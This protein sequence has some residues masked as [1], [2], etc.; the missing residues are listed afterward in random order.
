MDC[1][2]TA[3]ALVFA[4]FMVG[5]G[6][7]GSGDGGSGGNA[8]FSLAASAVTFDSRYDNSVAPGSQTVAA[9]AANGVVFLA[10]DYG[11]GPTSPISD[12]SLSTALLSSTATIRISPKSGRALGAGVFSETITVRGCTDSE[13]R[14]EVSG[15]PKRIAVTY[16]VSDS[17]PGITLGSTQLTFSG[18][19]GQPLPP[20]QDLIVTAPAGA[21]VPYT[22]S[23]TYNPASARDW[24]TVPPTGTATNTLPIKVEAT[25]FPGTHIATLTLTPTNATALPQSMV[26]H[27]QVGQPTL[28]FAPE[29]LDF[30]MTSASAPSELQQTV[31]V[32]G[33]GGSTLSWTASTSLPWLSINPTSGNTGDQVTVSLRTAQL[34]DL[35]PGDYGGFIN[36]SF[37]GASTGAAA[38][39]VRLSHRLPS[40]A[41]VTPYVAMTNST[42]QVI[43]RGAGF[44]NLTTARILFGA[45]PATAF[46][47]VS[48][49]ELRVTPPALSPGRYGV[50]VEN[51]VNLSRTR[52]DLVVVDPVIYPYSAQISGGQRCR[53]I[54]DA[55]RLYLY[56]CNRASGQVERYAF[57]SG[58]GAWGRTASAVYSDFRTMALAPDGSELTIV[59]SSVHSLDPV[60]LASTFQ[61][62]VIFSGTQMAEQIEYG[63]N[64]E[65]TITI[66]DGTEDA[67]A[68]GFD[69]R[70]RRVTNLVSPE[71]VSGRLTSSRDGSRLFIASR[72]ATPIRPIYYDDVAANRVVA[73]SVLR[74]VE[75][76]A[77]DRTGHRLVAVGAAVTEVFDRDF[78]LLG[79]LP[80]TTLAVAL[81]PNGQRAYTYDSGGSIRVFDLTTSLPSSSSSYPEIG[82]PTVPADSPGTGVVMTISPDA[83]TL[84]IAGNQRILIVPAP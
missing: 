47:K 63:N 67:Y 82:N 32:T 69:F 5:C 36:F 40:V 11:N 57:N 12:V 1:S 65:A 43:L 26:I 44:D 59:T 16:T 61:S 22:T 54:Y 42:E 56:V 37:S 70:N 38:L 7:G 15:S 27:Y 84:F 66:S 53:I 50:T 18:T 52:A 51:Q 68:R 60:S 64:G 6:G 3:A 71:S 34:Q 74:N 28:A 4:A 78:S 49:T 33:A 81:T 48:D 55:E 83:N 46:V 77:S 25:P 62:G 30:T 23:V 80:A 9:A 72:G 21:S 45:T 2:R 75:S 58:A 41:M 13:C 17:P 39:A 19:I 76:L 79:H 20:S 73:T 24:L 29:S 14:S 35:A 8:S 10:I 31:A